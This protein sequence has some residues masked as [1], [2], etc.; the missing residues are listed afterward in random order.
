[1]ARLSSSPTSK[2]RIMP[3]VLTMAALL[4]HYIHISSDMLRSWP[5]WSPSQ[6]SP[7]LLFKS[8]HHDWSHFVRHSRA[9]GCKQ[10]VDE[11]KFD[12]EVDLTPLFRGSS[13]GRL[14]IIRPH[15]P[16]RDET[17]KGALVGAGPRPR[18]TRVAQ[19][20]LLEG[21]G[22]DG[23]RGAARDGLD[24]AHGGDAEDAAAVRLGQAAPAGGE[25]AGGR[26]AAAGRGVRMLRPRRH[27]RRLAVRQEPR[28]R[29]HVGDELEQLR[30]R[31]R[32]R[33]VRRD[34]LR[35]VGGQ[36]E[37][38]PARVREPRDARRACGGSRRKTKRGLGRHFYFIGGIV[39]V[40]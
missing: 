15:R 31:V 2:A 6:C 14:P 39:F 8:V 1:M 34:R 17:A 7:R 33:P 24:D 32:Q 35:L 10:G 5:A 37:E 28:V 30:R 9:H 22:R 27:P 25:G 4:L 20:V 21:G 18:R 19:A 29:V 11:L 38:R 26:V 12:A 13:A 40:R 36:A 16:A 23:R 3:C